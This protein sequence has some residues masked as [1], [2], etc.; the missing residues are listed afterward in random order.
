MR[1]A[2][3]LILFNVPAT[4]P[5]GE[6]RHFRESDSGVL[7]EAKAVEKALEKLDVPFRKVGVSGLEEVVSA[8]SGGREWLVVNLV[9]NLDGS[10]AGACEVP[11]VCRALGRQ[12]TGNDTHCL[13]LTLDKNLAKWALESQGVRTPPWLFLPVG[14]EVISHPGLHFPVIVKPISADASEGIDAASVVDR[15]GTRLADAVRRIH[16]SLGQGALVEEFVEGREFNISLIQR[17]SALEVLPP[18]EIQFVDFPADRPRIVDYA[19]KW[20]PQTFEYRNTVRKIPADLADSLAEEIQSIS[21]AA[22][23]AVG[24]RDYARVDLRLDA[25]GLPYVLEV[26]ANPDISPDGGFAAA[27]SA[28]GMDHVQFLSILLENG[29]TRRPARL[30]TAGREQRDDRSRIRRTLAADREPIL[31]LLSAT[32]YFRPDEVATAAEVLDEAAAEAS[33][34]HYQSYT[35]ELENLPVGWVCWGQTPCTVGTFDLYWLVVSPLEQGK[36]IGRRLMEFAED[37]IRRQGGRI[38]VVETAGRPDYAP[39]RAFY[40]R[41]GYREAARLADFYAPGDDKVVFTKPMDMDV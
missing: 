3:V 22:W 6:G 16:E 9:E 20:L 31:S 29:S 12:F 2:E 38:I 35:F 18:A 1:P 24:C 11:T 4:E 33:D 32:G 36:G 30:S 40:A 21:L 25:H 28:A 27:L 39:T 37:S 19:A 26:N 23:G 13:G 8:V 10:A 17:G 7:D 14:T 34:G 41:I 15:P 5:M